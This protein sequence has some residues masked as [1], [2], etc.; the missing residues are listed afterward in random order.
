MAIY[1]LHTAT[2]FDLSWRGFTPHF[3]IVYE[4]PRE[5]QNEE[6]DAHNATLT[7]PKHI[8]RSHRPHNFQL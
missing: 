5:V 7:W 4:V 3:T 1:T 8:G 2:S 6:S